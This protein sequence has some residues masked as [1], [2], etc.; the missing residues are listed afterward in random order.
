MHGSTRCF[1]RRCLRHNSGAPAAQ[2]GCRARAR[3]T[4][5]R[6]RGAHRRL[7]ASGHRSWLAGVDRRQRRRDAGDD[8]EAVRHRGRDRSA[9]RHRVP[10]P[11]V[12]A[13]AAAG[14]HSTGRTSMPSSSASGH[15]IQKRG[16]QTGRSFFPAVEVDLLLAAPGCPRL[17]RHGGALGMAPWCEFPQFRVESSAG[18]VGDA[19]VPAHL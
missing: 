7:V 11:P 10:R 3:A 12:M 14:R 16:H 6:L 8:G 17:P 4:G 1:R 9:G 5:C 18:R 19:K 15:R 2:A 13:V